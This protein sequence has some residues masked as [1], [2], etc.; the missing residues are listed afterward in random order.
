MGVALNSQVPS[1]VPLIQSWEGVEEAIRIL[2]TDPDRKMT[3]APKVRTWKRKGCI[4]RKQ[5]HNTKDFTTM[6]ILENHEQ[7][8]YY[9]QL[10]PNVEKAVGRKEVRYFIDGSELINDICNEWGECLTRLNRADKLQLMGAIAE[11]LYYLE[12]NKGVELNEVTSEAISHLINDIPVDS[13]QALLGGLLD[14][15]GKPITY[16]IDGYEVIDC[17]VEEF[18]QYL[19]GLDDIDHYKA[20]YRISWAGAGILEG[21][22][23]PI[24]I[25]SETVEETCNR[26]HELGSPSDGLYLMQAINANLQ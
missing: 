9:S 13:Y 8:E 21:Q 22:G 24:S 7:Y 16:H 14:D 1:T 12:L 26:L 4:C 18:G 20:L 19:Q 25:C 3:N 5:I 10:L 6:G 15:S 17:M 23:E 2:E 11:T